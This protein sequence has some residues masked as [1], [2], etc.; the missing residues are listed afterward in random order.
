MNDGQDHAV[1]FEKKFSRS[2]G[3]E[4]YQMRLVRP[5]ESGDTPETF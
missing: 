2:N 4:E 3:S 5:A 1:A